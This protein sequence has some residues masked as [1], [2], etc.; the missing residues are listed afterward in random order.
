MCRSCGADFPPDAARCPFCGGAAED[1]AIDKEAFLA[2]RRKKRE[3]AAARA[4]VATPAPVVTPAPVATPAPVVTPEPV[5]ALVPQTT[6]TK[7]NDRDAI[8][9]SDQSF[10]R[11]NSTP[12]APL[13][14]V[15]VFLHPDWDV[16]WARA[17]READK[18]G[19]IL[20]NTASLSDAD[21]FTSALSE[22]RNYKAKNG[23]AYHLLDLDHQ[24]VSKISSVDVEEITALLCKVYDVAVPDYLMIVGDTTVIP[25][26]NWYNVCDDGDETVPSDL[27]YV[28]LDTSS[29]FDGMSYDFVNITQVG[30]IPAKAE[31]NFS[32][33]VAYF[34]NTMNF[35][36]YES[37]NAFAYSALVWE[38]TSEAE[39]A[40]LEPELITSPEYT[41]NPSARGSLTLLN[42]LSSDY[43]LICFNLHGSD[44]SHEWYGQEGGF[45]PEAFDKGLLPDNRGYVLMTEACYGARPLASESIVVNA[46]MNRCIAFVGSSRIAYGMA[47]GSLSCADVIASEFTEGVADGMTVGASFLASLQALASRGYM[48]EEEIKTLA[49]FALYGDPSV[50]LVARSTTRAS[51]GLAPTKRSVAKKDATRGISL[52]SCSIEGELSSKNGLTLFGCS[53]QEQSRLQQIVA[54]V[55]R[56][57]NAYMMQKYSTS[58]ESEPKVYKVTG[59]EEYRAVYE[60]SKGKVKSIIKM[61]LDAEGNVNKVYNSK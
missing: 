46:L 45:Y 15:S 49:E 38:R 51:K 12:I 52:M 28:T 34:K 41:S 6:A 17:R 26:A 31:N 30:R 1:V 43:N 42:K 16:E 19:I 61:H 27:A 23:V 4:A 48:D 21:A 57:G 35:S 29:P 18:V 24:M 33:A 59:K 14:G 36:L 47:N 56:S 44:G 7:N 32:E 60:S 50:C 2:E 8:I 37:V 9:S 13:S 25:N 40:H 39:F 10:S 58:G 3:A 55:R 22:Y 54:K 53:S 20:T 11:I 5:E